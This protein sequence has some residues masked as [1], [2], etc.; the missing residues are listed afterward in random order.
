[1]SVTWVAF[2]LGI[3]IS[4]INFLIVLFL[5]ILAVRR[6]RTTTAAAI[7]VSSFAV[8]LTVLATLFFYLSRNP[9]SKDYILPILVGFISVHVVFMILEIAAVIKVG[10]RKELSSQIV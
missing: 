9:M 2:G 1:M 6:D 3:S 7:T 10:D 4:L 5:S 8:R